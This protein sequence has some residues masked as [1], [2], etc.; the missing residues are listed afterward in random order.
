M[1]GKITVLV[2]E[3][4]EAFRHAASAALSSEG[5]CVLQASDGK[6]ALQICQWVRINII[7][8][9]IVMPNMDGIELCRKVKAAHPD[10]KVFFTSAA[11]LPYHLQFTMLRSRFIEKTHDMGR[12]VGEFVS[13]LRTKFKKQNEI[14]NEFF[15]ESKPS[16]P[17]EDAVLSTLTQELSSLSHQSRSV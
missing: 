10:I 3:D 5:F 6:E 17:V 7:L 11:S 15:L 4:S 9:D 12:F 16:N 8:T 2:V 1:S 14:F 13:I